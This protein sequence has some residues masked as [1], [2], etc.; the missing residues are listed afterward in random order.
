MEE[1]HTQMNDWIFVVKTVRAIR[2][3]SYGKPYT[4]IANLNL[5]SDSVYIDGLMTSGDEGFSREDRQTFKDYCQ[6]MKL[7]HVQ[8]DRYKNEEMRS[9][10]FDLDLEDDRP[11]D[12]HGLKLVN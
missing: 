4:G 10:S 12:D 11:R 6:H 8:F 5:N 7:K 1:R 2:V 9:F 3:G